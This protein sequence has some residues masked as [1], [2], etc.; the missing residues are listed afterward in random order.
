MKTTNKVALLAATLITYGSLAGVVNAALTLVVDTTAKTYWLTGTAVSPDPFPDDGPSPE[1]EMLLWN[2]NQVVGGGLLTFIANNNFVVEEGV[3]YGYMDIHANGNISGGMNFTQV[4]PTPTAVANPAT[5]KSYAEWSP[6]MVET[7]EVMANNSAQIGVDFGD[8]VFTIT[9]QA[10]PE[11]SS[12]LL[13]TAGV[14]GLAFRRRP[15]R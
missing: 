10:V 14:L 2:N 6:Q 3:D 9:F 12:A 15:T 5:V 1:T 8:P 11:P 7:F 13:G 4:A